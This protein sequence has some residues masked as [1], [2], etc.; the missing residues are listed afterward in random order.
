MQLSKSYHPAFPQH[1]RHYL[2]IFYIALSSDYLTLNQIRL[3]SLSKYHIYISLHTQFFHTIT[4]IPEL[5]YNAVLCGLLYF[6]YFPAFPEQ[7]SL[8]PTSHINPKFSLL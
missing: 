2:S 6:K 3:N 4:S 8:L 7:V 1:F 5:K